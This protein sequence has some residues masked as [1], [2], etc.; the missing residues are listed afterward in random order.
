MPTFKHH[1]CTHCGTS[2]AYQTSGYGGLQD[3]NNP[4]YCQP[5]AGVVEKAIQAALDP[6]SVL[7]ERS[8]RPTQDIT[9]AEIDLLD[10]E[11]VARIRAG[12]GIPTWRVMSP[13]FDM[14]RPNN[15]Q[16]QKFLHHDGRTYRYEWWS[17]EG[18][19]HGV[20]S[21]ECKEEI[22]TGDVVGPWSPDDYWKTTPTFYT[23]GPK[24]P[25]K[26]PTHEFKALPFTKIEERRY[27][28]L[29]RSQSLSNAR[30]FA[31]EDAK[32]FA[33]LDAFEKSDPLPDGALPIYSVT[34]AQ[35]I[36]IERLLDR[37]DGPNRTGC[38]N[39]LLDNRERFDRAPGS[40]HNH[41]AWEGGYLDHVREVMNLAVVLY[42]ALNT[43]RPLPFTLSSALLVLYLHDIEK[44][45]KYEMV[46][47]RLE[48]VPA[49]RGPEGKA[50]QHS[51]RE[52]KLSEYG[53][54]LACEEASAFR[55]VE[56][57]RDAD[58][59]NRRRVMNELAGFCHA[60]DVLS[61]RLWHDH[62]RE[63]DDSWTGASR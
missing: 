19:E 14:E 46:G 31:E 57:E 63:G 42:E 30:L 54:I 22:A 52:A 23:P 38:M 61:A 59:S 8:W 3:H 58:Y 29:E 33:V 51:F 49:M 16:H 4:T 41:Q 37:I 50:A 13:L 35:Y 48:E 9:I 25:R 62:P 56:G 40:V 60:C 10:D 7:F 32:V 43:K 24:P 34:S 28:M 18:V 2:Y 20:V 17:E 21:I 36:P 12:G 6:V 45:W 44:P 5:C 26:P 27:D 11:R 55:Y 1:R 47:G 39:L 53:I 15:V